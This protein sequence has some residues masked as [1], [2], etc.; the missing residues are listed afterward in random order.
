MRDM[1]KFIIGVIQDYCN[2]RGLTFESERFALTFGGVCVNQINNDALSVDSV[3]LALKKYQSFI[4]GNNLSL[5]QFAIEIVQE[6][7]ANT[8]YMPPKQ[9]FYATIK[10]FKNYVEGNLYPAFQVTAN[11]Q[12]ETGRTLLQAY[13][14]PRGYRE[15][16]MSGGN[17]DLIYPSEKTIVET[18]IWHDRERY[19]DGIVELSA[20]LV[21]QG[22]NTGYYVI[23]DNTQR[24]N[25][26]IKENGADIFDIRY[27]RHL[28]HC[29]FIKIKPIAPSKRRR[30]KAR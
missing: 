15:A 21:S 23:F 26:V 30:T 5:E 3:I 25:A 9:E 4:K 16:Q 7:C 22:Y 20:Y 28:I 19:K 24:D 12:E 2:K 14:L 8:D 1:N 29:F 18:K 10:N 13:L 11:P 27:G 6:I 17:S